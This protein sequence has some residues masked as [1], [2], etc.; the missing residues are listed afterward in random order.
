MGIRWVAVRA[1]ADEI[2]A[3]LGWKEPPKRS[4][5]P[6]AVGVGDLENGWCVIVGDLSSAQARELSRGREA[7]RYTA[8]ETSMTSELEAFRDGEKRWSAF[9]AVDEPGTVEVEGDADPIVLEEVEVAAARQRLET[10]EMIDHGYDAIASI[11]EQ[12]C[13][14]DTN[15]EADDHYWVRLA[16][17]EEPRCLTI[18]DGPE[19]AGVVLQVVL[20]AVASFV[21]NPR[22]G[23]SVSLALVVDGTRRTLRATIEHGELLV[24]ALGDGRRVGRRLDDTAITADELVWLFSAFYPEGKRLAQYSWRLKPF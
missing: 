24:L 10:D 3:T 6:N 12:L 11:A 8:D 15:D 21:E 18:D 20:D 9:N 22:E 14:F 23:A 7:L 1:S 19:T 2:A 17:P 5:T 4:H 13:G 16:P